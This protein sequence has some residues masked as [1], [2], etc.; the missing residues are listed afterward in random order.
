MIAEQ[1]FG[2][3]DLADRKYILHPDSVTITEITPI[4]ELSYRLTDLD[5]QHFATL[6][7]PGPHKDRYLHEV[8]IEPY[9]LPVE[10]E[11]PNESD[12]TDGSS[13]ENDSIVD[14][15]HEMIL[16]SYNLLDKVKAKAL[17]KFKAII[18]K[19]AKYH[20]VYAA[21]NNLLDAMSRYL[22]NVTYEEPSYSMRP[23][24]FNADIR[25]WYEELLP[26]LDTDKDIIFNKEEYTSKVDT[27]ITG[28]DENGFFGEYDIR[29]HGGYNGMWNEIKPAYDEWKFS[30]AKFAENLPP[31]QRLSFEEHTKDL[32]HCIFNEIRSLAICRNDDIRYD[33]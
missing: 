17:A 23:L 18:D 24:Q 13:S 21:W 1:H 14:S 28:L 25:G 20:N 12:M 22:I 10:I 30:R 5:G 9:Y 6:H 16:D 19:D 7:I 11:R 32:R 8:F 15:Q 3:Y 31:H 4:S 26:I 33:K 29:E 27:E 2:V